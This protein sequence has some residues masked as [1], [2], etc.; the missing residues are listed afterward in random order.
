MA[1]VARPRQERSII[2][3]PPWTPIRS[4]LATSSCLKIQLADVARARSGR[5]PLKRVVSVGEPW[6][7]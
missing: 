6:F 7:P 5:I 1:N 3:K 2:D 4:A